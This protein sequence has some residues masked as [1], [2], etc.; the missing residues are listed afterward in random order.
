MELDIGHLARACGISEYRM[1][2]LL[3]EHKKAILKC[4]HADEPVGK[5]MILGVPPGPGYN[6]H[7]DQD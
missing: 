2:Q 7:E 5:R 6:R 1:K 4:I 3:R